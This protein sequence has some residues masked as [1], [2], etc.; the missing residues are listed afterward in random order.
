MAISRKDEAR[1]LSRDELELVEQSR[2][3]VLAE[4][5]DKALADL[6]KRVRERRER[7]LDTARRQRREM[8][9]KARA[10]GAKPAS[11]N[12]GSKEKAAALAGALKRLNAEHARR[13][14][15][16]ARETTRSGLKKALEL[17]KASGAA[18][19]PAT[20]T[21]GKGMKKNTSKKTEAITDPRE[22][23]RVSQAVKKSQARKDR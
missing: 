8:R 19:R 20:Q 1:L 7:A 21:A 10:K 14:N 4:L 9:G 17:K 12:V 2:H 13:E 5:A 18:A 15:A 6:R 16:R 23:G 11:D 3:P 22:V